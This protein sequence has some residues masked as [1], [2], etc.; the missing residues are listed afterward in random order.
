[1]NIREKMHY[2]QQE[3]RRKNELKKKYVFPNAYIEL[4]SIKFIK[5]VSIDFQVPVKMLLGK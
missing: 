2:E 5:I 1:M 3:L 4:Q